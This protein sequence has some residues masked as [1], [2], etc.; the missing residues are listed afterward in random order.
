MQAWRATCIILHPDGVPVVAL[1]DIS[2][3]SGV[4][5]D[6]IAIVVFPGNEQRN[7][8]YHQGLAE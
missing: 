4:S 5:E 3:S 7:N 6:G 8:G 2:G 1:D